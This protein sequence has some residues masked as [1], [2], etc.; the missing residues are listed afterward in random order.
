MLSSLRLPLSALSMKYLMALLM[1]VL[2]CSGCTRGPR[3]VALIYPG[4]KLG[5]KDGCPALANGVRVG[6]LRNISGN[7]AVSFVAELQV[8]PGVCLATGTEFRLERTG[9]LGNESHVTAQHADR[10][11]CLLP[12]DTVR[13]TPAPA[14]VG[15]PLTDTLV[16]RSIDSVFLH[17][18][19][20]VRAYRR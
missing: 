19:R 2:F 4:H 17:L 7:D 12:A 5:I 20:I 13:I 9:V 11:R 18:G 16:R 3:L 6:T 15:Q 1:G 8:E 10:G 14:V